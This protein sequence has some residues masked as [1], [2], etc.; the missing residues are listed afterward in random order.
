LSY[1]TNDTSILYIEGE[2]DLMKGP[3][4]LYTVLE[5]MMRKT[6]ASLTLTQMQQLDFSVTLHCWRLRNVSCCECIY[7]VVV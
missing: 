4:L 7:S 5:V 1:Y 2:A 3:L 6:V